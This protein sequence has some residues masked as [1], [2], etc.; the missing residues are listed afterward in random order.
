[1]RNAR[2]QAKLSCPM[3]IAKSMVKAPWWSSYLT[4]ERERFGDF[5]DLVLCWSAGKLLKV[6]TEASIQTTALSLTLK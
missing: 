1:M 6:W 2:V 3:L 4:A 5:S